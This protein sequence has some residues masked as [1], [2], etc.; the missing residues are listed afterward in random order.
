MNAV[1]GDPDVLD[2]ETQRTL[3]ASDLL[4]MATDHSD[5]ELT[6]DH[7]NAEA[8]KKSKHRRLSYVKTMKDVFAQYDTNHDD[9]LDHSEQMMM[10]NDMKAA[11]ENT[12][13]G[14][15]R[16]GM[17]DSAATLRDRIV[18]LHSSFA[19][20]QRQAETKRQNS[21]QSAFRTAAKLITK[22]TNQMWG[23][24]KATQDLENEDSRQDLHMTQSVE[25]MKLEEEIA[26]L[27]PKLFKS[28]STLLAMRSSER[29]LCS[30]RRFEEAKVVKVR[31]DRVETAERNNFDR[32]VEDAKNSRRR[33]LREG[34]ELKYGDHE[35]L[36]KRND[37]TLLRHGDL[38]KWRTN[39]RMKQNLDNMSHTHALDTMVQPVFTYKPLLAARKNHK[40]T[41]SS[42]RG[43]QM[44]SKVATG[45]AAVAGLCARHDFGDKSLDG[46][47]T[48]SGSRSVPKP[49][50]NAFTIN[51]I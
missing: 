27:P 9:N 13:A 22:Q 24:R 49:R 36:M 10:Y 30:G 44:L 51:R 29:S 50:A 31:A 33:L 34:Q 41:S 11:L 15:V 37:W 47:I 32:Q 4:L 7:F 45:R 38:D 17:Y 12:L 14:L 28:S 48:Y 20:L 1:Q 5:H 2:K 21:E 46:T 35:S 23:D 18:F 3:A 42:N 16:A 40:H 6:M 19:D 25:T 26:H 8:S 43:T 39:N